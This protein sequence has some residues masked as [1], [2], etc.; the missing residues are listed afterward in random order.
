VA[1]SDAL[2]AKRS[3][4]HRQGDHSLCLP[5]RCPSKPVLAV[6]PAPVGIVAPNKAAIRAVSGPKNGPWRAENPS[7]EPKTGPEP[8]PVVSAP[9]PA[10]PAPPQAVDE[11]VERSPGGI[12]QAVIAFCAALPY[13]SPDPRALLAQI[14]VRLAQRVDET[15]A[16]PAAVRE[17]RTMLM[18]LTEVPN[19]PAGPVDEARLQ[20][21]QRKLDLFLASATVLS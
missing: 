14:C 18:Q 21:A 10:V 7:V 17:L 16:M 6:P 4:Y 2:R 19:Q 1:D 3:R 20:R 15:G 11:V 12:E 9:R 13:A 8:P 5:G